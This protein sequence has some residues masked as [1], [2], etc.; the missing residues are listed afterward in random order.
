MSNYTAIIV[1][2][3]KGERAKLGYN[4]IFYRYRGKT[5]LEHC[6][7]KFDCPKIVVCSQDDFELIK[8]L[9]LAYSD[10]DLTLGGE[11]RS[12]SVRAGLKKAQ[13]YEFVLIHDG[14]RPFVSKELISKLIASCEVYD[15]AIP[16]ANIK[17][18]V[19]QKTLDG[20]VALD[21]GSLMAIQTPQVFKTQKIISAYD[22]IK[23]TFTDDSQ[24][25]AKM[26]G[27]CNYVLGEESN[28]KITT[29]EDLLR[30][31]NQPCQ[32]RA[33]LGY[34][35]HKLAPNRKLVLGGVEIPCE[36]GLL[37][38]SDADAVIHA[39]MDGILS[40]LG[41][42]DIGQLFPDSDNKFKDIYSVKLLEE[43]VKIL[44]TKNADI[45]N[46]ALTILAEKPKLN[47][48]IPKMKKLL[49][50]VLGVSPDQIGITATTNEGCGAIGRG[51]GIACFCNC[52]LR[53]Y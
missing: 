45:N 31:S 20:F 15:N 17:D 35:F 25:Y 23:E 5:V 39:L 18:T 37:G 24:I 26:W 43:V 1:C 51:E 16:Y 40:A 3:G 21:R 8:Q 34:D 14:A 32:Y 11:T 42:R 7:D 19:V 27:E 49:A 29:E 30:L 44:K 38:H 2:A 12:E 6:L 22:N 52:L 10:I 41:E 13:K 46:V 53:I 36:L 48:Y 47:P 50:K 4:K 33:G 9:T 28:F